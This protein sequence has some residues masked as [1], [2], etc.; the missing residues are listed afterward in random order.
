LKVAQPKQKQQI[1]AQVALPA[2]RAVSQVEGDKRYTFNYIERI[3]RL[4]TL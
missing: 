3:Y 4:S 2:A 1:N